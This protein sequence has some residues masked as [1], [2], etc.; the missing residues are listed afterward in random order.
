M[1]K[2]PKNSLGWRGV[3]SAVEPVPRG[4]GH[5]HQ[6]VARY[7]VSPLKPRPTLRVVVRQKTR[8]FGKC[9]ESSRLGSLAVEPNAGWDEPRQC[10]ICTLLSIH[11][12]YWSSV[13]A[14]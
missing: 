10:Q 12:T 2:Y 8:F 9:R 11:W 14:Q 3:E 13:Y 6:L 4:C 5:L 1:A 7:W